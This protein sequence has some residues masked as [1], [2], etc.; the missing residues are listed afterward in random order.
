MN[1]KRLPGKVMRQLAGRAVLQHILDRLQRCTTIDGICIATSVNP[2]DDVI[3]DFATHVDVDLYRGELDNVAERMLGAATAAKAD[4]LVRINGDSPLIDPE[5]VDSAVAL[6][7]SEMPDL[8]TN[9][10]RRTFPKGQS[11]EVIAVPAL[12][13]ACREMRSA[14]EREHVTTWFYEN[15]NRVRIVGFESERPRDSY[16]LSVD[17]QHDLN[18]A[19][20][21]LSHLGEPAAE[22]GLE[23]IIVAADSIERR[24]SNDSN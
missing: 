1:S 16:Q 17:T 8:V 3:A 13:L 18:R 15:P 9:V 2:A 11:I 21:I 14:A 20:A 22:H 6:Y 10:L 23:A 12:A 7:H 5:I 19:E 4:A 24:A